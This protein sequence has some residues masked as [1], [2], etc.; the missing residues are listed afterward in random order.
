M[1][2][3]KISDM[4]LAKSDQLNAEDLLGRDMVIK[5]TKVTK[6]DPKQPQPLWLHYE[7]DDGKPYKPCKGMIKILF[8]MWGEDETTYIGRL[9]SLYRREDVSFGKDRDIGGIRLNGMSNIEKSFKVK[10]TE[11]RNKRY[12]YPIKKLIAESVITQ[13]DVDE[14]MVKGAEASLKGVEGYTSWG[15]S[16][17]GAEKS[18]VKGKLKDWLDIAKGV[19][20]PAPEIETEVQDDEFPV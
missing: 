9:L 8:S 4:A 16:L 12:E 10:I 13:D 17:T 5:I 19:D 1:T 2:N 11:S 15:K 18:A 7:G 6:K 20:N 14:L 3:F